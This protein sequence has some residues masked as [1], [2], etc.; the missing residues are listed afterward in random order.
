MLKKLIMLSLTLGLVA[1][2]STTTKI[3]K[4]DLLVQTR[5]EHSIFLDPVAPEEQI[6]YV[7]VRNTSGTKDF[8]LDAAI[9]QK[10]IGMGFKLTNNPNE[11]NFMLQANVKN[12]VEK[13]LASDG[14]T[15]TLIGS[16]IGGVLGS[17]IGDGGGQTIATTAGAVAGGYA[18]SVMSAKTLDITFT[19][20]VDI[21][22]AEKS[23]NKIS[24]NHSQNY[25]QG[26]TSR[27]RANYDDKSDWKK[28]QTTL[29][30]KAN[31]VNLTADEATAAITQDI[32]SSLAGMF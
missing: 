22:V 17:T 4:K 28:Y 11:A 13:R 5:M 19:A 30:S 8:D 31:K 29:V 12:Y 26:S 32:A 7:K 15:E 20:T 2:A 9:K 23:G 24:Y 3:T 6:I 1:C 27:V 25:Q 10:M 18:G 16:V 14:A 21:Q